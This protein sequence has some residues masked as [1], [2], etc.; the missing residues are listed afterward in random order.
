MAVVVVG[1]G[2]AHLV[3]DL[4]KG[5]PLGNA[6]GLFAITAIFV[7]GIIYF[8]AKYFVS[9][10]QVVLKADGTIDILGPGAK[11]LPLAALGP[12]VVLSAIGCRV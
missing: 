1:I 8:L 6:L 9:K 12:P 5:M 7:M 4:H 2:A 10:W 11:K 3:E